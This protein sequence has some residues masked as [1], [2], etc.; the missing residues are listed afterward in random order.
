MNNKR[1]L[2]KID[3]R[4]GGLP[5]LDVNINAPDRPSENFSLDVL[6]NAEAYSSGYIPD[7]LRIFAK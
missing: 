7:M 3:A 1:L 5:F 4:G 2:K 6:L